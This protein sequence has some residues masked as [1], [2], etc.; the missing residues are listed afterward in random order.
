MSPAAC[1]FSEA[2]V[3][4]SFLY[5]TTTKQQYRKKAV[6]IFDRVSRRVMSRRLAGPWG[7]SSRTRTPLLQR[8]A[9]ACSALYVCHIP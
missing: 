5:R 2:C 7:N 1:S 8:I 3:S 6:I 4:N 9:L